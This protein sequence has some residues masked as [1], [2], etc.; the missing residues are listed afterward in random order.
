MLNRYNNENNRIRY[1]QVPAWQDTEVSIGEG[2]TGPGR[3]QFHP[4]VEIRLITRV[5]DQF[6]VANRSIPRPKAGS[7]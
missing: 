5:I 2:V 6:S 4:D 7:R 1:F 3:P